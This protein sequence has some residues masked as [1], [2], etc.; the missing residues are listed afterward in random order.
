[1]AKFL[2]VLLI[3]LPILLFIPSST[4]A[5]R[6]SA[7]EPVF[8]ELTAVTTIPKSWGRLVGVHGESDLSVLLFEDPGGDLRRVEI[9]IVKSV[10]W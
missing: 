3:L 4:I 9:R 6:D 8:T 1:M 5:Q 10:A 2:S 7:L